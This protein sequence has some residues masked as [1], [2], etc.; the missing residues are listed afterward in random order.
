M[1]NSKNIIPVF[2]AADENY[3]PYLSVTLLSLS[4]YAEEE[5]LYDVHILSLGISDESLNLT[6]KAVKPNVKISVHSMEEKIAPIREYLKVRLRDYYSE[7]IY[8]RLFIPSM[9]PDLKKAVYLDC[10]IVLCDDVAKLYNLCNLD[11]DLLCAVTDESVVIQPVFRKYVERHI[12]VGDPAE[13]FNSGVLVMNLEGFRRERVEEK[14]TY[15]IKKYNFNTVAPDQDYLNFL[16]RGRV[17]YLPEGWNKQ[18]IVGRD[19]AEESLHLV[20]FNM[21]NKPWHYE[22]VPYE[23][24]FWHFARKTPFYAQLVRGLSGYPEER[25]L[26][27]MRRGEKLIRTAEEIYLAED[28]GIAEAL[29]YEYFNEISFA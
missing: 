16:C 19:I 23:D 8:Y 6:R 12:G 27:D 26:E 11:S 4:E 10:D 18:A 24:K 14:F 28:D 13:Y 29:R 7:S 15:L 5:N 25:R 21:F 2:F 22:N 3:L 20:H 9:F 1:A 17:R